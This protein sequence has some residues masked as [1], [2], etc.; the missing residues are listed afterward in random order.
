MNRQLVERATHPE[1]LE[2]IVK[3][4]GDDWRVHANKVMGGE[5]A[6]GL[7]ADSAII[8]RDKSFST[9]NHDVLFGDAEEHIRTRLGDEGIDIE[10]DPPPPSPLRPQSTHRPDSS[11]GPLGW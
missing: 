9:D 3:D 7:T 11:S 4:M 6:E 2:A 10:L 1:A 8:R 5:L